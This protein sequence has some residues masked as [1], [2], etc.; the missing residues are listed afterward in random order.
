ME[1]GSNTDKRDWQALLSVFGPC[2]IRGFYLI[3]GE[4]WQKCSCT[5]ASFLW[6]LIDSD[7]GHL[8]IAIKYLHI[9]FA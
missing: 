6:G 5:R 1:H 4:G 3:G 7:L 8:I 9:Y 2:S